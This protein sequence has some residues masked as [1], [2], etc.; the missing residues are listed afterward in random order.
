MWSSKWCGSSQGMDVKI[1]GTMQIV[2]IV[3]LALVA[4]SGVSSLVRLFRVCR[5]VC[6][7]CDSCCWCRNGLLLLPNCLLLSWDLFV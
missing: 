7:A 1:V 4:T 6:P 5:A 3:A 2:L